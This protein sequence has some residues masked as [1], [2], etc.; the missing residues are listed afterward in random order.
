MNCVNNYDGVTIPAMAADLE[1][2]CVIDHITFVGMRQLKRVDKVEIG[3]DTDPRV[4]MALNVADLN[5][6]LARLTG[7]TTDADGNPLGEIRGWSTYVYADEPLD[8][9]VGPGARVRLQHDVERYPH[10]IAPE[11]ALGTVTDI[12]P[13]FFVVRLDERVEGAEDW[14][15][16]VH[17]SDGMNPADDI[18]L[19]PS[20]L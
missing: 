9:V 18:V 8:V 17:W 13:D 16:E 1:V 20:P 15:N 6:P 4:R 12:D 11:G 14:D 10:F 19:A 7:D 3:V 2:P 5:R